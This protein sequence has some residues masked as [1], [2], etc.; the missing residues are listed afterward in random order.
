MQAFVLLNIKP[1]T[2]DLVGNRIV[3]IHAKAFWTSESNNKTAHTELKYID[4]G[5]NHIKYIAGGTFDPLINLVKLYLYHNRLSNLDN[6]FIVNLNKLE[7]FNIAYNELRQLPTDWLPT[8]LRR[9]YV[10]GNPVENVSMTTFERA[11]NLYTIKLSP[12]AMI[13]AND[14]FGNLSKLTTI[15]VDHSDLYIC[16]CAYI[17]Y[18]N[19][20]SNSKVCNNSTD[21][22]ASIRTYLKEECKTRLPG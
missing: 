22:Y 8:N 19:T 15:E 5:Y 6:R 7:L 12:N 14:T 10:N 13:I 2:L 1:V 20:K 17:W 11:F 21:K 4:I 3:T 18:L 16:T 9:L